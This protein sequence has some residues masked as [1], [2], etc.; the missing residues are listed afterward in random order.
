M[1]S[2]APFLIDSFT[3]KSLYLLYVNAKIVLK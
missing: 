2:E 3:Q 1:E